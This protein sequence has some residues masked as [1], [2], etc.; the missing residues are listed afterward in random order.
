MIGID[1]SSRSIKV[2]EV[3]ESGQPLLRTLCWSSLD[4]ESIKGGVIQDVPAVSAA[5]KNTLTNCSPVAITGKRVVASIPEAQS[6]VRVL[7]LP[8]MAKG[9]LDE[10]VKWAVRRHIPFDL[11]RV[12]VDWE[13]LPTPAAQDHC[14]VLV[15]AAQRAVVDPLL[16][17]LDSLPVQVVALELEAQAVLRCLLPREAAAA[18]HVQG[19]LVIDLGATS[20]NV[21]FFDQGSMRYT[22]S[23]QSGG[24]T[25]SQ[26]LVEALGIA[27]REAIEL[28]ARLDLER[29]SLDAAAA[30]VRSGVAE[31]I[32]KVER[33]VR[34]MSVQ[35]P[36]DR[37]LKA[38]LLAGGGAN[39]KGIQKMFADVFPAV[40]VQLGNPW[41][42][43]DR[44]RKSKR[45]HL[46]TADALQFTTALGLALREVDMRAYGRDYA[47]A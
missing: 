12:Y 25:L 21:V 39:L 16:A 14:R 9:E 22:A 10:A 28:K 38:I 31:L 7:E 30:T 41:T 3:A 43:L 8:V 2:V 45:A 33:V 40:S 37:Q 4:T 24:D 11:E 13:R 29:Q 18:E 35:L 19:V 15:G 44:E 5:L 1:I 47:T 34:E 27:P 23:I 17:V 26:R 32:A 36:A 6:F 20:T 46:S 42:N